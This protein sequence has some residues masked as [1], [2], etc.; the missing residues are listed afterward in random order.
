MVGNGHKGNLLLVKVIVQHLQRLMALLGE[1]SL[2]HEHH[3][4]DGQLKLAMAALAVNGTRENS[5][6]FIGSSPSRTLVK[7][8]VERA[9]D[10]GVTKVL[11]LGLLSF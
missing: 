4:I 6:Y 10:F 7:M 11:L 3:T 5:L 2:I 1:T 8:G 9:E